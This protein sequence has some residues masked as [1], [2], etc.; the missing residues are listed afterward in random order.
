[1]LYHLIFLLFFFSCFVWL[2]YSRILITVSGFG[3]QSYFV[4]NICSQKSLHVDV[5]SYKPIFTNLFPIV[6]NT[7]IFVVLSV[8]NVYAQKFA[9][10]LYLFSICL[11]YFYSLYFVLVLAFWCLTFAQFAID[12][13][14]IVYLSLTHITTTAIA[15]I[16]YNNDNNFVSLLMFVVVAVIMFCTR[17][18]F[19][20]GIM[21]INKQ[22]K[23]KQN[24]NETK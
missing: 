15:L 5:I 14:K 24:H 23:T 8:F 7:T 3:W 11:T 21:K 17:F 12:H 6:N 10:Y 1:M 4:K 2:I 19:L 20:F 13:L 9:Y 16:W 22:T 18:V